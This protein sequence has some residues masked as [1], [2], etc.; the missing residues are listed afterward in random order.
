MSFRSLSGSD[1]LSIYPQIY[2]LTP[3]DFGHTISFNASQVL[4]Q[5]EADRESRQSESSPERV[6]FFLCGFVNGNDRSQLSDSITTMV[7]SQQGM[8]SINSHKPK[9][10]PNPVT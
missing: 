6:A 2:T 9:L 3:P 10:D 5:Q 8:Y 7:I 1:D 4:V